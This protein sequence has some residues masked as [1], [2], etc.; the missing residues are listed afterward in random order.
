MQAKATYHVTPNTGHND[1]ILRSEVIESPILEGSA[2]GGDD[3]L[4]V[5][6]QK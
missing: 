1:Q 5:T 2:D 6:L 3:L 4:N